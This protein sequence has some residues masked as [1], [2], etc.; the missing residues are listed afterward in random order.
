M[1]R[2]IITDNTI[3]KL[4]ILDDGERYA[5]CQYTKGMFPDWR[6]EKT[7]ILSPQ[8]AQG[9]ADFINKKENSK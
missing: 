2:L 3:E 5:L 4:E 6:K 7:I 1:K 9:V 8:E